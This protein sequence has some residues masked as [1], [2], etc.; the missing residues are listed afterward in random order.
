MVERNMAWKTEVGEGMY[1]SQLH[2][3]QILQHFCGQQGFLLCHYFNST[4]KVDYRTK[5]TT[6][7]GV[8]PTSSGI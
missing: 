4:L 2:V 1:L 6:C 7:I 5:S 8:T 3:A